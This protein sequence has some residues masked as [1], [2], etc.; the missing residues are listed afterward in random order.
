[1]FCMKCGKQL[2]DDAKFC[3]SCGASVAQPAPEPQPETVAQPFT[4]DTPINEGA[5]FTTN[6]MPVDDTLAENMPPKKKKKRLGL[7][8]GIVIPVATVVLLAVASV[9]WFWLF[10]E[11]PKADAIYA[12]VDNSGTAYVCYENGKV[13]KIS[14]DVVEAMMTPDRSKIVVV[15][16]EGQVYW[17]DIKKSEKHKISEDG[18]AEI[19]FVT[20]RFVMLLVEREKN[21]EYKEEL[22]R[23]EF[24]TERSV[25]VFSEEKE[26]DSSISSDPSYGAQDISFAVAEDGKIKILTPDSNKLEDIATYNKEDTVELIGISSDGETVAWSKSKAG[27]YSVVL[28]SDGKEE[29]VVSGDV[30]S[31]EITADNY[32]DYLEDYVEETYDESKYD[33]ID[34]YSYQ[35]GLKWG[36]EMAN[37]GE[38]D[39]AKFF[40]KK[41]NEYYRSSGDAPSFDMSVDPNNEVVVIVGDDKTVFVKDGEVQKVTLPSDVS[42]NTVY[43]TNGLIIEKDEDA[44]KADGYYVSVKENEKTDDGMSLISI[45]Y[46]SFKDGERTKLI[47]KIKNAAFAE[48]KIIYIDKNDAMNCAVVN[49]KKAE[50]EDEQRI[51]NDI[52]YATAA[53][54]N[55]DYIYFLKNYSEVDDTYDLYVY[56]VED[57]DSEKIASDVDFDIS[58]SVDGKNVYYFTDMAYDDA[59]R[60]SYGT[61]KVYNVKSEESKTVSNDVIVYSL[62]SN[63]IS[64]EIDPKSFWIEKYQNSTSE[65]YNF[66]ICYYD[67]RTVSNIVKNLEY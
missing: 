28:Y 57:D 61:L 42:S 13:V 46:I 67:G 7:I 43:T 27:K 48:N 37:A 19:Y 6:D 23:Y 44:R 39:I 62:T 25:N 34:D 5:Q 51:G 8:L 17:T 3:P 47:S 35:L 26:P 29:T 54:G 64:G 31:P 65:S 60:V 22:F 1:M 9:L 52:S 16:E 32:M 40:A 12:Y 24:D 49:T 56:D 15:E 41:L 18:E 66:N 21:D 20:D 55:S 58:V 10:R 11:Q 63:L 4:D 14:G 45:Y 50:L 36:Q 59:N 30:S 53:D 33:S 38:S 2:P